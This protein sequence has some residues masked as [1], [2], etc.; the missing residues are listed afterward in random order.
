MERESLQFD[1]RNLMR[2]VA[3]G[4]VAATAGLALTSCA[5]TVP[6]SGWLSHMTSA[7][8]AGVIADG[9]DTALTAGWAAWEEG[10]V[11]ARRAQAEEGYIFY[12]TYCYGDAVPPAII[13]SSHLAEEDDPTTDRMIV[14]VN[15]GADSIVFESWA[16]QALYLF[17]A[18]YTG[19]K[20]GDELAGFRALC[21]ISLLPC[22]TITS[23]ST[24]TGLS[25]ILTYKTRNGEVEMNRRT[26]QNGSTSVQVVATGIPTAKNR[27]TSKEFTLDL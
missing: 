15:G 26:T 22:G 13:H 25:E 3:A 21:K 23:S 1:R 5:A 11:Q 19:N 14:G 7:L 16:W 18:E 20:S 27:P 8:A 9:L 12:S 17:V 2:L 4:G 24:S 10:R 6:A